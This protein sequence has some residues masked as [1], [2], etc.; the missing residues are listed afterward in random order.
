MAARSSKRRQRPVAF[1]RRSGTQRQLFQL[2]DLRRRGH[3]QFHAGGHFGRPLFKFDHTVSIPKSPTG[4]NILV[5]GSDTRS[6]NGAG[7]R[8][9]TLMIVHVDPTS[10][11]LS[12]LSIPRDLQ[13]EV[14][15]HG[16]QKINAAYSFGGPALTIKTVSEVT[17]IKLDHYMEVD[18]AAFEDITNTLGGVYIDVD[19]TYND[20]SIQFAPGYQLL[21]GLNALKYVRTRHDLNGDFGRMERQQHFLDAVREQAMGWNL[22]LKLPSLIKGLFKNLSTDLHTTDFLKLAYWAVK[23]DGSRMKQVHIVGDT[24]TIDSISYVVASSGTIANAVIDFLTPP[25]ARAQPATT[26]TLLHPPRLRAWI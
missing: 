9:D 5:V 12:I 17:G 26:A 6:T 25:A 8:S 18:F 7:G 10:N 3:E 2:H 14:P 15:G 22:P 23:L 11:F 21:N 13:V 24:E 19:R 16:L 1:G 20:G 4:M